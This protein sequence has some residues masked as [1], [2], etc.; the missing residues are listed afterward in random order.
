MNKKI[1]YFIVATTDEDPFVESAFLGYE[2]L[3][4]PRMSV[5]YILWQLQDRI[6][7]NGERSI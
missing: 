4:E 3:E 2:E 7:D 1:R 6:G 5:E